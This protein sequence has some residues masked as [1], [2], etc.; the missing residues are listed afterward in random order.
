M[1][2]VEL[3]PSPPPPEPV[4]TEPAHAAS[5]PMKIPRTAY[6]LRQVMSLYPLNSGPMRAVVSTAGL[7]ALAAC[8]GSAWAQPA[9]EPAPSPDAA[10]RS[11]PVEV[12]VGGF[13]EMDFGQ[14]C[15][16]RSDV[17]GCTNGTAFAGVSL[18]P[19]W[20]VS[21]LFSLGAVG[22]VGWVPGGVSGEASS[23]GSHKD[24]RPKQWRLEAEARWH[25][26]RVDGVD[27]WL[28]LD[29]G[30]AAIIDSLDAYAPGGGT[31]GSVSA[32]QL[33]LAGG[34]GLGIDFPATSF[35]ALG[36]ELRVAMKSLGH[37]PPMLD[38]VSDIQA[39]EFGT[40]TALSLAV[41]GTFLAS[42]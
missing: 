8:V 3:P 23:D 39:H 10:K 37:Q 42:P 1:R 27:P 13:G 6:H 33:G 4:C 9:T 26:F 15:Q 36:V 16:R 17:I 30:L 38:A 24:F 32:T 35:L 21:S 28:G 7:A 34:A 22:A 40:L 29:A 19:R 11:P 12:G 18:A 20:R 5:A 2:P 25:P 31:S 41:S 14:I